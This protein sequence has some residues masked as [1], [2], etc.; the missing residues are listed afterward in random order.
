MLDITYFSRTRSAFL[1][2]SPVFYRYFQLSCIT[3]LRTEEF[4]TMVVI[5]REDTSRQSKRKNFFFVIY[6]EFA[7]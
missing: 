6:Y 4:L 5:T 7:E 3:F 1:Y 2:V